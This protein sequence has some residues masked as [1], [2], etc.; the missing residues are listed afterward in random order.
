[1]TFRAVPSADELERLLQPTPAVASSSLG[2]VEVEV[3]GA[4]TK[5]AIEDCLEKPAPLGDTG[6]SI[7]V[8]RYLPHAN[9]GPDGKLA[10]VSDRPVNPAVEFEIQREGQ[11]EVETGYSFARFP[12]FQSMH[13]GA[14][15]SGAKVAFIASE[16]P[17][18]SR[19]EIELLGGPD[20]TL[21]ARF[22]P[23]G[24]PATSR[25]VKLG[26]SVPT[27]FPGKRLTVSHWYTNARFEWVA[28]PFIPARKDAR[29]PALLVRLATADHASEMWLQ[30]YRQ[31]PVT[32]NGKP[33]ELT[34]ADEIRP[35]GFQVKLD[36]FHLGYYPG[37]RRPRSFESHITIVDGATGTTQ[38]RVV[39]MNH[40][41]SHGGFTLFQSSY[42]QGQGRW[43][44]F[45][46][47]SRDPGQL[48]TFAGYIA[49]VLG[50]CLVFGI[51][52]NEHRTQVQ[53]RS[54]LQGIQRG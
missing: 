52:M 32:V 30:K 36:R 45:L 35:L 46:S 42:Q 11:T 2:S 10:N 12:D 25:Q 37:T 33:Y 13:G 26:E 9:V 48:I 7:R 18:T 31:T 53:V 47:V 8:L 17:A 29:D 5:V 21:W 6:Y 19:S 28:E 27:P 4:E 38:S 43:V 40:P 24:K 22:E 50:M 23:P 54:Q 34:F 39:S 14:D 44:S 16:S 49:T 41:V 15:P 20:S 51:R 1:V 3:G